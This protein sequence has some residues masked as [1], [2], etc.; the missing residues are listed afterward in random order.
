MHNLAEVTPEW[1]VI[2]RGGGRIDV[3]TTPNPWRTHLTPE[4][5]AIVHLPELDEVL[6]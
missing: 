2:A 5:V 1:S 4:G 6:D 3:I